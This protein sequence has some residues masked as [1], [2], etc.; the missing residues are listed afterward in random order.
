MGAVITKT[1]NL[2]GL[3]QRVRMVAETEVRGP[4]E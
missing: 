4:G 2:G 1:E 3:E